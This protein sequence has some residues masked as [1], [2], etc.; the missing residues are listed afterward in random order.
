MLLVLTAVGPWGHGVALAQSH[1]ALTVDED[2]VVF[3]GQVLFKGHLR[4]KQM[5]NRIFCFLNLCFQ[6]V[7]AP[8]YFM[9]LINQPLTNIM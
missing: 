4:S 2:T 3:D 8:F 6:I 1:A 9:N 5:L 7:G